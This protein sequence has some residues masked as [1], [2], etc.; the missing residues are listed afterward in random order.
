[1]I[2][3]LTQQNL[4][5]KFLLIIRLNLSKPTIF[6]Y[7]SFRGVINFS[8]NNTGAIYQKIIGII[9]NFKKSGAWNL[10]KKSLISLIPGLYSLKSHMT[11]NHP[12]SLLFHNDDNAYFNR[13]NHSTI[14]LRMY[15]KSR[16]FVTNTN[17]NDWIWP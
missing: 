16:F 5:I 7:F 14:Y 6:R 4:A 11:I 8:S 10:G 1:M 2:F 13:I 15:L 3:F 12:A 9:D 17:S